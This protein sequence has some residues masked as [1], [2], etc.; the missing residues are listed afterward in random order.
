ME[1]K[2]DKHVNQLTQSTAFR[3]GGHRQY[4]RI[5]KCDVFVR[6]LNRSVQFYVDQLGFSVLAEGGLGFDSPSPRLDH[7]SH[8]KR[9]HGLCPGRTGSGGVG[10]L[11]QEDRDRLGWQQR[12]QRG[13]LRPA[14]LRLGRVGDA[15]GGAARLRGR[16]RRRRAG[17][18]RLE[19]DVPGFGVDDQCIGT[20]DLCAA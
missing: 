10:L 7:P 17:G 13:R 16:V 12:H 9:A 18:L 2:P 11:R 5:H 8:A 1:P 20:N 14:H 6:D 4:L 3:T 15:G 19:R